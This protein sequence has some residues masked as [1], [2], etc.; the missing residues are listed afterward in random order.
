MFKKYQHIHF[1][2]IGG[3]GMSGIA[4]VLLTLGYQVSGSDLKSSE[5]TKRLKRRGATI[6]YGHKSKHVEGAHVVVT[7]SAVDEKNPE[8]KAAKELGVPVVPRAEMLAEL[9]RLK[10]GIAVAGSHGKTTTTAMIS[11]VFHGAGLDPTMVIG[12]KVNSL[13]TN[14]KLGKGDF[15]IAEAD[16]SDGSFLKL[17]PTIGV[18]T[19]IDPEHLERYKDFADLKRAF[20]DFANKVP[21]YGS[22]IVCSDHPVVKSLM[23]QMKRK[24]VSYGFQQ[25]DYMAKNVRQEEDWVYFSVEAYGKKLGE[26]KINMSGEHHALN[27]LATIAVAREAEISVA[28]VKQGLAKFKGVARRFEIL[29]RAG[30]VVVDDYA[31][32]PVEIAATLDAA[33]KGWEERRVI[34]VMQPHRYSR[35]EQLFDDFVSASKKADAVI[36][37]DVYAAG[38]KRNPKWTGEKLCKSLMLKYPKKMI[39]HAA[40]TEE[41]MT[42]LKPWCTNQDLVM[43]LGAGDITKT[44]RQ[45]CKTLTS[46]S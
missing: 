17:T 32:H 15:L 30:P 4:D 28:K 12:G 18:I 39:T 25:A 46:R 21:F 37:M 16:E 14:A 36:V 27:A 8:V 38:E 19:N 2:G 44:A 33:K 35:L 7:S 42:A 22:V 20:V 11:T 6:S 26:F 13:R 31:H 3:I 43:F 10:W 24:V 29:H 34:M 41:V 9:M 1:V 5:T 45:F 23:P 40:K